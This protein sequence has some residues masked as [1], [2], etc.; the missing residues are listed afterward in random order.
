M[1]DNLKIL[2]NKPENVKLSSDSLDA[3]YLGIV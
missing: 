2:E 1:Y 3:Y